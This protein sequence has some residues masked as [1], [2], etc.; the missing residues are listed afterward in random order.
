MALKGDVSG[1]E[2]LARQDLPNDLVRTNVSYYK[3][4]ADAARLP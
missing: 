2:R 1:A 4:L 3:A